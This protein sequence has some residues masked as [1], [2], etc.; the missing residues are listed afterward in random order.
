[1]TSAVCLGFSSKEELLNSDSECGV[2]LNPSH[3]EI[4]LV[5]LHKRCIDLEWAIP[6]G[7]AASRLHYG[8]F[9]RLVAYLTYA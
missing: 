3:T 7:S 6:P 5:W 4:L 9:R 2:R 1:M 8:H